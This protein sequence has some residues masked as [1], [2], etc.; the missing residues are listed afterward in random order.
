VVI[1]AAR[2]KILICSLALCAAGCRRAAP[3]LTGY[4]LEEPPRLAVAIDLGDPAFASQLV[5]GWYPVERNSWRWTARA[6]AVVL[7]PPPAAAKRGATLQL[8]FA[9]PEPVLSR[10]TELTLSASVRG[11][12][13]APETY[14]RSGPAIYQRDIPAALLTGDSVRFDFSLDK[15]LRAGDFDP[16]ELGVIATQVGLETK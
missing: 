8:H 1:E 7:R 13:L 12:R 4:T 14:R 16:R 6:F 5:S 11:M 2:R 10:L 3:D 15:A 9:F